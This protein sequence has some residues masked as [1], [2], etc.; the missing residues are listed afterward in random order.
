MVKRTIM[1][2]VI[3]IVMYMLSNE[4]IVYAETTTEGSGVSDYISDTQD[5]L[6]DDTETLEDTEYNEYTL[7]KL[8]VNEKLY[9]SENVELLACVIKLLFISIVIQVL[10]AGAFVG[11]YII[12]EF[13][14]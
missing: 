6:Y 1:A 13:P 5:T 12:R 8:M 7:E 10:Y 4:V 9:H 2:V 3:A 14:R 11:A